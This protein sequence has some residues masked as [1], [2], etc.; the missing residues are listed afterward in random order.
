MKAF[1]LRKQTPDALTSLL[2]EKRLRVEELRLLS[3]QKKIK[4]VKELGLVRKDIA[5]ILTLLRTS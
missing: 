4:N 2:Q 5:R 3:A 1:D